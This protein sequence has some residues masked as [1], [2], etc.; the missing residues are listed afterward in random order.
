VR[1]VPSLYTTGEEDQTYPIRVSP[2]GSGVT[3]DTANI[4]PQCTLPGFCLRHHVF[5]I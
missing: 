4:Y 2:V 1:F 3:Y 5:R